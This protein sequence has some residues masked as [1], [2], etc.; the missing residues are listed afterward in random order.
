MVKYRKYNTVAKGLLASMTQNQQFP[1]SK[2]FTIESF[3]CCP[4]NGV[5]WLSM[6]TEVYKIWTP[7]SKG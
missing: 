7:T 1:N 6:D 5:L 4:L 3:E 2:V